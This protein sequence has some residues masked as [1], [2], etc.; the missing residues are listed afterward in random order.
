MLRK[1]D[2][3]FQD[4]ERFL[5]MLNVQFQ[6]LENLFYRQLYSHNS[7]RPTSQDSKLSFSELKAFFLGGLGGIGGGTGTGAAKKLELLEFPPGLELGY[8]HRNNKRVH[9]KGKCVNN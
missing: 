4:F 6:T 1:T 5:N 2:P 9:D 7:L 3:I 8:P